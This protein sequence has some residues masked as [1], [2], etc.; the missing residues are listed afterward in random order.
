MILNK[1][2]Q[3]LETFYRAVNITNWVL[4]LQKGVFTMDEWAQA[5]EKITL[6]FAKKQEEGKIGD[7]QALLQELNEEVANWDEE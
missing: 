6:F 1:K 2:K 4:L 7:Y 3:E 5:N